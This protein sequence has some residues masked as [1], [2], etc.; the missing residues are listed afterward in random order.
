MLSRILLIS[1]AHNTCKRQ[2]TSLHCHFHCCSN[3][4]VIL[5][6]QTYFE[7][8][9]NSMGCPRVPNSGVLSTVC[10]HWGHRM[11]RH[12]TTVMPEAATRCGKTS[13]SKGWELLKIYKDNRGYE[14]QKVLSCLL[15]S[16]LF[17]CS[18][19]SFIITYSWVLHWKTLKRDKREITTKLAVT[20]TVKCSLEGINVQEESKHCLNNPAHLHSSSLQNFILWPINPHAVIIFFIVT[21][22]K[23]C[24]TT[25]SKY[26]SFYNV[27]D[28]CSLSTADLQISFLQ[29][30]VVSQ[31]FTVYI[32][33]MSTAFFLSGTEIH[34][35]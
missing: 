22:R 17:E 29:A 18:H 21:V 2:H 27:W 3:N 25:I 10:Y 9:Y 23:T 28:F 16:V 35:Q 20:T 12:Y 24:Q 7:H 5:W 1:I 13:Y 33:S 32:I 30:K 8:H 34:V 19:S 14:I 31:F 11:E 26:S 15:C 4:R 6:C